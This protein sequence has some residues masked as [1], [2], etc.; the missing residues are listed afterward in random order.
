MKK[1]YT[2]ALLL[3][4]SLL[5][6]AFSGVGTSA[7]AQ[8]VGVNVADQP[9]EFQLTFDKATNRMTAWYIPST[10]S[11]HRLV[12]AQFSIVAPKGYTAPEPGAGRDSK[13]QI[14]N[15]NGVWTDFVFDND[16]F[17]S[18]G[19]SP[20]A[21]LEGL[22]VHQVGM[23]PQAV[24]VGSVSAGVPV[25]L[26]S[27]PATDKPGEVRIVATNEQI[28]KEILTR[29][30]SNINNEMSIQSPVKAYVQARQRY[31]KNSLQSVVKFVAP[32]LVDALNQQKQ[33][34]AASNG[35]LIGL[36]N[37]LSANES[38][39]VRPN[40]ASGPIEVTYRILTPGRAGVA[41]VDLQ[42][43]HKQTLVENKHHEI[44]IYKTKVTLDQG[45]V[46]GMYMIVLQGENV[47]KSTKLAIQK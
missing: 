7:Q 14:T 1:L 27:F 9:V 10:S 35:Q 23:A 46:A 18:H 12:T 21:S 36:D 31:C 34:V 30:G 39:A 32:Q 28:Q 22:A 16:L 15:I 29:Y 11:T 45:H 38:L 25:P 47:R 2:L 5:I 26:F 44:G 3:G 33:A 37:A 6:A 24:E 4:Q 19:K 17:L 40:P 20:L 8:C 13:L 43:Q 41:L 42:G